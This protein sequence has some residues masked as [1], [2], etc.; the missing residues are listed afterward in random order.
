MLAAIRFH[1]WRG[2]GCWPCNATLA[3]ACRLKTDGPDGG[4]KSVRKILASLKRKGRLRIEY[5][6]A[7]PEN[8]TGRTL[9]LDGCK[10]QPTQPTPGPTGPP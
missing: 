2:D 1:D 5:L 8:R 10:S 7:T 3:R 4:E 6:K 9:H